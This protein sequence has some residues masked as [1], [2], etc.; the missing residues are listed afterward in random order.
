M[1]SSRQSTS[2]ADPVEQEVAPESLRASPLFADGGV[3]L[4]EGNSD[5]VPLGGGVL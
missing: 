4:D 2:V 1:G 5:S 3:D